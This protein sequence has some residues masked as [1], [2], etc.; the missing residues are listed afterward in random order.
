MKTSKIIEMG[1]MNVYELSI[2]KKKYTEKL[3]KAKEALRTAMRN[4][5]YKAISK[6]S[7]KVDNAVM[8]LN[9]VNFMID[10]IAPRVI[11]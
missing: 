4:M 11:E 6:A 3:S 2:E 7:K 1:K 5:D 10:L 8:D 9:T